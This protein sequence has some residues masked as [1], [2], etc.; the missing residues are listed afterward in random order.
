MWDMVNVLLL[1]NMDVVDGL[2]QVLSSRGAS[3]SI[4]NHDDRDS[5]GA[6]SKLDDS[7]SD[8]EEFLQKP[9]HILELGKR[10]PLFI[11]SDSCNDC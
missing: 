9:I 3:E 2:K 7:S 8:D 5:D 11:P 10:S 6:S 1:T 4:S